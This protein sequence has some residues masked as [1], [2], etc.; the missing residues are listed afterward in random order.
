MALAPSFDGAGCAQQ[1]AEATVA[2]IKTRFM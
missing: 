1:Q 2:S